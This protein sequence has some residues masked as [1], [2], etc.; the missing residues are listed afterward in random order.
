[1]DYNELI[2]KARELL[3]PKCRVCP[4]CDGRACRGEV[5]G[6]GGKGSGATFMRNVSY[7]A[8]VKI[9]LDTL[10]EDRGQDT[11]C[12]FFG[13][14]FTL[15]AF[16][17]PIGGMKMN[18]G[19]DIS[20]EAQAERVLRGSIAA[21]SVA[22]TG[23]SP[24]PAAYYGPLGVIKQLGGM[25]VPTIKPWNLELCEPKIAAAKEA[26]A[27]AVCMDVDA[28]GLVNV[29]INGGTVYPKSVADMKALVKMCAPLPF[30]V[31]GVM[32]AKGA[33]KAAEAGVYGIVVSNHGG[34]VLD[35]GE[36][37]AEVLPAIRDELGSDSPVKVFMDGGIRT[38]LD[39]FKALALGADAVLIGRPI[40][41][42]SFGGGAEGV[43]LY[44]KK[45]A[46]ELAATMI[47]TGASNLK[48]I[49][50]DMVRVP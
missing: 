43:E 34:R 2:A 38:G 11:G 17:A 40:I 15:P 29:K 39:V 30:I 24:V 48:E 27:L 6:A 41:T 28:A 3:A 37:T 49:T 5:P 1:M 12:E 7:L 8:D 44:L 16:P 21:G 18:Y 35:S 13:R 36:A 25:G 50:R 42:A 10:Y 9:V 46:A 33:L 14:K 20:E 23:D 19:S 4:V 32:S 45:V 47:M 26:G 31:K 22:F